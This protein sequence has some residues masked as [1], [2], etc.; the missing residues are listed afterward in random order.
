MKDEMIKLYQEIYN[1]LNKIVADISKVEASL[2][3]L[4]KVKEENMLFKSITTINEVINS[5]QKELETVKQEKIIN[6]NK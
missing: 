5:L 4:Q 3:G 6:E 1:S 2:I